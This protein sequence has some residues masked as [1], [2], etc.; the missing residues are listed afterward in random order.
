MIFKK[1]NY[2]SVLI[3]PLIFASCDFQSLFSPDFNQPVKDFFDTYTNTAAIEEYNLSVESYRDASKR[4][5]IN[6]DSECRIELYM[7]NPQLYKLIPSVEFSSLTEADT[8][9]IQIS[10]QDYSTIVLTLPVSFLTWSD[11]GHDISPTV[12]LTEPL[13]GRSFADYTISLYSNSMPPEVNNATIMNDSNTTFVVAFDMPSQAELALR[14]K[15]LS[16]LTIN[17]K[18]Y[19]VEISD[20]GSFTFSDSAFSTE[21]AAYSSISGKNFSYTDRSVYYST[22]DAF[23]NGDKEYTI[24]LS[25]QA[26]LTSQVL[27]STKITKLDFPLLT[28][29]NDRVIESKYD[30]ATKEY[31]PKTL[32]CISGSEYAL[33]TIT[34][35]S[36]DILGNS[37]EQKNLEVRY[38]LFNGTPRSA[39]LYKSGS[40]DAG[41][42]QSISLKLPVASWYLEAYAVKTSYEKSALAIGYIRVVD[43]Y[44]FVSEN[45]SDEDDMADGT[46]TYPYKTISKAISDINGRNDSS[47]EYTLALI[48]NIEGEEISQEIAASSLIIIGNSSASSDSLESLSLASSLPVCIKNLTLGGLSLTSENNFTAS[49]DAVITRASLQTGANLNLESSALVTEL[50]LSDS[51]SLKITGDLT[52]NP[53]ATITPPYYQVDLPVLASSDY[54]S[55]NYSKIAVKQNNDDTVWSVTEEGKLIEKAKRK[56][57]IDVI[58]QEDDISVEVR[59]SEE[60]Y[61]FTADEGYDSYSWTFDGESLEAADPLNPNVITINMDDENLMPGL[62]DLYLTAQK[63][64]MSYSYWLQITKTE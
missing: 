47:V 11:E 64:G 10:Q 38:N 21:E 35:P 1:K 58:S 42:T 52:Q 61:T 44:I 40:F 29:E 14:H 63:D 25:D 33:I 8:S 43:S 15:D 5:C 17:G 50:I 26:G 34:A 2:L 23:E 27:A 62:Y 30:S 4:L 28:D 22:G 56:I 59:Q 41:Q 3:L 49:D 51:S 24:V 45:G 6:S 20:D 32:P 16:S 60:L 9:Q 37:V 7:R 12:S 54:L 53:A 39:S 57:S 46:E 48:G 55:A 18:S 13:S 31:S 19:P 36:S